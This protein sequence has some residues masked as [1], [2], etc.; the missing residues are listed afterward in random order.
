MYEQRAKLIHHFAV[1]L[2]TDSLCRFANS[3]LCPCHYYISDGPKLYKGPVDTR[4]GFRS[5]GPNFRQTLGVWSG[6][7]FSSAFIF[8]SAIISS[9]CTRRALTLLG[10]RLK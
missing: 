5:G 6:P 2:R 1:K 9:D 8:V 10:L 3:W 7:V 4:I